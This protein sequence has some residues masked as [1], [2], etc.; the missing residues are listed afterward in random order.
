MKKTYI[1]LFIVLCMLPA[2][3]MP[4][5]GFQGAESSEAVTVLPELIVD[6]KVN[7][8]F[9]KEL[10]DYF[11]YNFAFRS[12]MV[13]ADNALKAKVFRTS[14]QDNVVIG[15]KGYLFYGSSMNDYLGY[16][17]MSD[18]QIAEA[19]YNLKL[20]QKTLAANDVQMIFTIA[21]NKNSLYPQFM[22]DGYKHRADT[23][24]STRLA[25]RLKKQKVH[26]CDLF[27]LFSSQKEILYHK[28]D[29]H[30]NNKGAALAMEK[31]LDALG[32]EHTHYKKKTYT[33]R[34]DFQGDLYGMLYP[35]AADHE[36]EIEYDH[37]TTYEYV[38]PI[39]STY[40]LAIETTNAAKD[41]SV[42]VCRDSFGNS[43]LPFIADQYENAYF[44]RGLPYPLY[45]Y[46]DREADT[47]IIELVERNLIFLQTYA[48]Q[49]AA[50]AEDDLDLPERVTKNYHG[51]MEAVIDE[52]TEMLKI[53]GMMD[54]NYLDE[55]TK[56]YIRMYDKQ[57][58]LEYIYPAYHTSEE[59]D[60]D[61]A[62][63]G[64]CVY[65]DQ[66]FM[67]DGTYDVSIVTEYRNKLIR[68]PKYQ[69]V[70]IKNE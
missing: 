10:G 58:D 69:T 46:S 23:K 57:N 37:Q 22:P 17:T 33:T 34:H 31:V 41:G 61:T 4:A 25:A 26:Y 27:A 11:S 21:P 62:H 56:T 19:A 64:Y 24:N 16:A 49:L 47:V 63:L 48:P 52:D 66:G 70:D 29:S 1:V 18:L 53:R 32:H 68:S 6:G 42:I 9:L 40:D 30:W 45:E 5:F 3:L 65:V 55:D 60:A 14:G 35:S 15:K 8:S 59:S 20:M 12:Q 2:L 43:W 44:T 38:D 13:T 28:H 51:T 7:K 54:K 50:E 39:N 67:E 36:E